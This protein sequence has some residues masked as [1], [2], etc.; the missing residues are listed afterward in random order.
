MDSI[1]KNVVVNGRMFRLML[2]DTA[3]QEKFNSLVPSAIRGANCAIIVF[4]VSD[5]KSF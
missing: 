3:G 2:W 1:K 5:R 4:D